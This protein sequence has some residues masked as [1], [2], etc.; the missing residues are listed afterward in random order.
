MGNAG[1]GQAQR[2]GGS[3]EA[4]ALGD[5]RKDDQVLEMAHDCF[6]YSD[7][8]SVFSPLIADCLAFYDTDVVAVGP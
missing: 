5:F 3:G 2:A 4:A 1:L 6:P 8:V 7:N